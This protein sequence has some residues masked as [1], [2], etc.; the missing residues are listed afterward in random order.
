MNAMPLAA[1]PPADEPRDAEECERLVCEA[2]SV[3]LAAGQ[4]VE[5]RVLG[6]AYPGDTPRVSVS[7]YFDNPAEIARAAAKVDGYARGIYFTLNPLRQELLSRAMNR[8]DRHAA[9]ATDAD[10]ISRRWL[11]LDFDPVRP[12]CTNATDSEVAAAMECADH[13]W[14]AMRE[15]GWSEPLSALSGN[16]CHLLYRIDLPAQ[17]D[18]LVKRT[19]QGLSTSYSTA[20][21]KIDTAVYNLSRIWKL[22]GTLARKGPASEIR[23]HRR[24]RLLTVKP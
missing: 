17:D 5:L 14:I 6:L 11:P 2:A 15:K 10:V 7:G 4:I 21:V 19:L 22:P 3:I 20:H 24:A 18:G 8:L 23:P 16:G 9:A 1:M 13:V 12:S